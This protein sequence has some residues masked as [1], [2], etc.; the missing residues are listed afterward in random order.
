MK[1]A[2][3]HLYLPSEEFLGDS[4]EARGSLLMVHAGPSTAQ[5][6]DPARVRRVKLPQRA[7]V[8]LLLEGGGPEGLPVCASACP[9]ASK[10]TSASPTAA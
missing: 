1:S 7:L 3:A 4:V 6:T 8:S 10:P 5:P 9:A 2:G